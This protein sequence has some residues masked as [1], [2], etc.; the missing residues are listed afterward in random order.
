[1][2]TDGAVVI[3]HAFK[4][5]QD[6]FLLVFPDRVDVVRGR[7]LGT[8]LGGGDAGVESYPVASIT[9]VSVRLAGIWAFLTFT[10]SNVEVEFKGDVVTVPAAREAIM[11]AKAAV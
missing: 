5:N 11:S 10:S 4:D 3:C 1:M 6:T 9:S 7:K 8:L 2:S